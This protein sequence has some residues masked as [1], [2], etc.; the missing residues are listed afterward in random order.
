MHTSLAPPLRCTG[1]G[2]C[3][4]ES[5]DTAIQN[6]LQKRRGQT[7]CI[8]VFRIFGI[9]ILFLY[10]SNESP[11]NVTFPLRM[12][13]IVGAT[14]LLPVLQNLSVRPIYTPGYAV[15]TSSSIWSGVA[16]YF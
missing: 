15:F 12:E 13:G 9:H 4:E 5:G 3:T 16:L 8:L 2:E 14:I 1:E 11:L 10:L 6:Y 7:K